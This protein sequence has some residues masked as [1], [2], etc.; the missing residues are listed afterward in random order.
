MFNLTHEERKVILFLISVALI[1]IGINFLQKKYSQVKVVS[2]ISQDINK[3]NL[4]RADK[5]MLLG[6][7]GIGEKLAE[8]IIEYR[9]KQGDFKEIEELQNIKGISKSKYE[10]IKDYFSVE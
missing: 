7:W 1:G 10:A 8:R 9:Q 4:N 6:I 5:E 2:Y 3:V